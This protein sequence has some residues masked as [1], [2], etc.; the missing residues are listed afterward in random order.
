[1]CCRQMNEPTE[2]KWITI[3]GSGML[4]MLTVC[5]QTSADTRDFLPFK[6]SIEFVID[7]MPQLLKFSER[8][9]KKQRNSLA[10]LQLHVASNDSIIE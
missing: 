7:S 2:K 3:S 5:N 10:N 9:S 4:A 8:L 1:M 6:S